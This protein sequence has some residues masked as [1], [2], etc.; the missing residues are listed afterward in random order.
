MTNPS[1]SSNKQALQGRLFP[2]GLPESEWA[3]FQA[4]GFGGQV[5]GIIYR[6]GSVM[7]GMPLGGLGTGFISL[8]TDGTLDYVSTI[9]NE[10]GSRWTA[11]QAA[12]GAPRRPRSGWAMG[13]N[14]HA[15]RP[16]VVPH[17]WSR[18]G[19]PTSHHNEVHD[20]QAGERLTSCGPARSASVRNHCTPVDRDREVLSHPVWDSCTTTP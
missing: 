20:D 2:A 15:K 16:L 4:D 11:A 14:W 18:G 1:A 3:D 9:F 8:G 7:P 10:Y 6:G 5:T 19:R 12:A 17:L 13:H